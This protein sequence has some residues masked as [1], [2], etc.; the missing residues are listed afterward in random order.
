MVHLEY[1]AKSR[2][3]LSGEVGESREQIRRYIRLT[4]LIPQLLELVDN[5]KMGM[6]PAVE[7]SYLD[8]T[9][10]QLLYRQIWN[11]DCTPSHAQ[12]IRIRKLSSQGTL[13][14]DQLSNIMLEE[15]PNQKEKIHISYDQIREYIPR[16]I[17]FEDTTDYIKKALVFYKEAHP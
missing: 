6:R 3:I 2:D 7:L 10:Q 13:T 16:N 8:K 15:K 4:E 9:E 12:A 11:L 1:G 5:G 14:E 17:P